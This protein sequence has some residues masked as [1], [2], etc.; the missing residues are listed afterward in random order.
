MQSDVLEALREHDQPL[1][2]YA[3]LGHLRRKDP[4]LAPTSIYRALTALMD[5]GAIHRVESK[6][7]FVICK[8]GDQA[9]GFLIAICE[10]C[11]TV[12]EHVAPE[13][14]DTVSAQALKSG[15]APSR[16]VIEVHGR[17]SDCAVLEA[18]E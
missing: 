6:K 16:H 4:K 10:Q 9:T 8:H 12:E 18:A 5:K 7:A 14:I 15:F 11:G 3:L 2:A 1:T 17:C 13:L